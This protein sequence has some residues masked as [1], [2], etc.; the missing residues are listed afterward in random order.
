VQPEFFSLEGIVKIRESIENIRDRWNAKLSILGILLTQVTQ[1]RKLTQEVIDMLRAEMGE[2]VLNT[3]IRE[4][5]SVTESSG[6]A[7]SVIDYD[8]ASNGAKDYLAAAAE[9]LSRV[10]TDTFAAAKQDSAGMC[11]GSANVPQERARL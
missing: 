4:N 6:H 3:M 11:T 7:Q 5:A 2:L 10:S 1:R 9:I 8:R